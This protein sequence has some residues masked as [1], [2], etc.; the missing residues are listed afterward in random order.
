MEVAEEAFAVSPA[1]TL[2]GI[3]AIAAFA[4]GRILKVESLTK[5]GK[6]VVYEAKVETTG[7]NRRFESARTV[8][9]L[10]TRNKNDCDSQGDGP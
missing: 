1:F 6:V 2:A 7:K 10:T 9:H 3:E 5:N 4:G 8:N